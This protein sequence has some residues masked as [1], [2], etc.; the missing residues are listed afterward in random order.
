MTVAAAGNGRVICA[1]ADGLQGTKVDGVGV[2]VVFRMV[3]GV[4][5]IN[6][7]GEETGDEDKARGLRRGVGKPDEYPSE[8]FSPLSGVGDRG[9]E[10]AAVVAEE[11]VTMVAEAAAPVNVEADAG[12]ELR[13]IKKPPVGGVDTAAT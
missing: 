13:C 5:A 1:P 8:C 7:R 9:D 6:G 11:T 12:E 4:A 10:A 3:E 2:G